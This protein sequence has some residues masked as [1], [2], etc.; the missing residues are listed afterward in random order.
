[1][2]LYDLFPLLAGSFSKWLDHFDRAK[3]MGFDWVFVNPI[4][5]TGASGSLYSIA[6]YFDV[7]PALLDAAAAMSAD[8]QVRQATGRAHGAGL[9]VREHPIFQEDGPTQFLQ[10]NNP[11]ILL[12]QKT[13]T[14]NQA[15]ALL[16]L[17]KDIWSHQEFSSDSLQHFLPLGAP[18]RDVSPEFPLD[19]VNEPFHN[20]LRPGQGI[21]L[22]AV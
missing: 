20:A 17:N 1:M 16:I 13:S 21:V 11:N 14:R 3:A 6:D 19:R 15:K 22:L 8:E 5:R 12:M 10:C 4:Q 9:R 18:R 2:I 7:N